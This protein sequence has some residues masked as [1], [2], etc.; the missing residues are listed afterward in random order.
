MHIRSVGIENSKEWYPNV[1]DFSKPYKVCTNYANHFYHEYSN[2]TLQVGLLF[3][4]NQL[5]VP[6]GSIRENLIQEKHNGALSGNF[7]VHKIVVLVQRFYYYPTL[8]RDVKIYVECCMV[9]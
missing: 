7:G 4:G 5:C 2:F 9:C 8:S 6:R 1:L 3:K